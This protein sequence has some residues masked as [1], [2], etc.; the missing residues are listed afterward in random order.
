MNNEII[1]AIADLKAALENIGAKPNQDFS[2]VMSKNLMF[3][4]ADSFGMTETNEKHI[5]SIY[6]VNII[7]K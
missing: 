3:S 1:K 6:G 7:E 4:I 5:A 2:F